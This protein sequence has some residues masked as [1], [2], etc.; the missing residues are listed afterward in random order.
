MQHVIGIDAGGSK[1]LCLTARTDGTITG[2]GSSG[3]GSH[4]IADIETAKKNILAAVEDALAQSGITSAEVEYAVFA[5]AGADF[6]PD[7]F[8]ML[9]SAMKDLNLTKRFIVKNDM[10]GCL[11]S[12]T[13]RP[14]GV[15]VNMGTGFNAMGV[16][17]DGTEYK[18][19]SECGLLG[20]GHAIGEEVLRR[21]FR[22]SDGRKRPTA[23][24][25]MVLD[26]FG[27][28][29][30]HALD[31]MLFIQRNPPRD[32]IGRLCPLALEAAYNGDQVACDIIEAFARDA[33]EMANVITR[34]LG[35]EREDVEI[36]LAGSVFKSVGPL[37][38]DVITATIH[39]QTPHAKL[40][41]PTYEPVVGTIMLALE[42]LNIQIVSEVHSNL[43]NT[44]PT[45]L[46][47]TGW[48]S[49][50]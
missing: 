35:L 4:E 50:E 7:D 34:N 5:L 14:Y 15:V 12:G 16:G 44:L 1:T 49:N 45:D 6:E 3:C 8:D 27:A 24:T 42:A 47:R 28:Q 26:Y 20:G 38:K 13:S 25:A 31:R 10:A 18:R 2:F 37:L 30:I 46:K 41:I 48:Q 29:D 33:G 22:A 32:R 21:V 17:K 36:V 23:L 11:R 19:V 9:T 39:R 40:V 43:D